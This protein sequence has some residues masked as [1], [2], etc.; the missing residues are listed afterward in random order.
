MPLPLRVERFND[1][2]RH[3]NKLISFIKQR[4]DRPPADQK[5]ALDTLNRVAA[6]V[7][8]IMK[9]NGLQVTSLEEHDFNG[10]Y[11]GINY[12]AGECIGLVLRTKT[13]AWMPESFVLS[14]MLHELTHCTNMHHAKPFWVQLQKYQAESAKLKSKGYTGEGF[15][16]QGKVLGSEQLQGLGVADI[17]G[18]MPRTVCGGSRRRRVFRRKTASG[19]RK[20]GKQFGE[21]GAKLGGDQEV[22]KILDGGKSKATPR[23]VNSKRGKELRASAAEL[24]FSQ[25]VTRSVEEIIK[26]E[27]TEDTESCS[28]EEITEISPYKMEDEDEEDKKL[29]EQEMANLCGVKSSVAACSICTMENNASS[30]TCTGCDT[31]F[32]PNIDAWQCA[33]VD[34]AALQYRNPA[35]RSHCGFCSSKKPD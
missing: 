33:S 7:Y 29:L 35:G 9:A 13:N 2:G 17:Q 32:D 5:R 4:Q 16:S 19:S 30:V 21:G 1:H 8:P 3:P 27:K 34:C 18:D 25:Q 31:L 15:W 14:V 12:N 28:D 24:R 22:R 26:G 20:R 23:V 10:E 11:A 6:F